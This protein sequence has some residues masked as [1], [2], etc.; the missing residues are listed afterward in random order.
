MKACER[1]GSQFQ[2]FKATARFCSA[3][4]RVAAHRAAKSGGAVVSLESR[5]RA[6]RVAAMS[7]DVH[8]IE[9]AV[10][11]ELGEAGLDSVLGQQAI[12]LARRLDSQIDPS[13][14][15]VASLSKQLTALVAEAL[16]KT[17]GK[18]ESDPLTEIQ[19]SAAEVRR[20]FARGA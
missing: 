14:S 13:G 11:A 15:A 10:R 16:G 6:E 4:C 3:T 17:G 12:L 7:G 20:R 2:A 8:D 18:D 5:R 9:S 19:R 1:C